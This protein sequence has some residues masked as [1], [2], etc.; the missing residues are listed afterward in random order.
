MGVDWRS[1]A[2]RNISCYFM[3]EAKS[4]LLIRPRLFNFLD[5]VALVTASSAIKLAEHQV[6]LDVVVVP[7][8]THKLDPQPNQELLKVYLDQLRPDMLVVN[9]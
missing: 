6:L 1:V 5:K 7:V 3:S 8:F 4:F 9:V 2:H